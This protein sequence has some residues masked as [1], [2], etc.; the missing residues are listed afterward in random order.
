MMSSR[1]FSMKLS[2]SRW[3]QVDPNLRRWWRLLVTVEAL[4][5]HST[6]GSVQR[7]T[8]YL[9]GK[10]GCTVEGSVFQRVLELEDNSLF[11]DWQAQSVRH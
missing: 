6:R 1:E 5:R 3:S 10:S 4:V 11:S 9:Q 2:K 8:L 7:F